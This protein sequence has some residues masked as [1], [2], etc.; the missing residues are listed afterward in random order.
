M[1]EMDAPSGLERLYRAVVVLAAA[2][3]RIQER[4]AQSFWEHLCLIDAATLP[5]SVRT[6]FTAFCAELKSVLRERGRP[7]DMTEAKAGEYARRLILVYDAV[8]RSLS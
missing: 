5:P 3:G 1:V 2:D 8:L 6:D 4:L 7:N